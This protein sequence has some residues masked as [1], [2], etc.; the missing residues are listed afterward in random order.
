[1]H[2]GGILTLVT[3][4]AFHHTRLI[5][6]AGE[7]V[8]RSLFK[9]AVEHL[10]VCEILHLPTVVTSTTASGTTSATTLRAVLCEVTS[11]KIVS[12]PPTQREFLGRSH[13]FTTV[14]A[15][16]VT[17]RARFRAVH[18]LMIFRSTWRSVCFNVSDTSKETHPQLR[19]PNLLRLFSLQSRTRWPTPLQLTHLI[20]GASR[21]STLSCLQRRAIWPISCHSQ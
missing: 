16:H 18:R 10:E 17:G 14:S 4:A 1:M 8:L 13:T 3:V 12:I 5:T 7:V 21:R 15:L 20:S 19:H 11:W 9:L 6:V 2:F